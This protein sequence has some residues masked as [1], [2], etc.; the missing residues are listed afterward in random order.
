MTPRI[1]VVVLTYNRSDALLVVLRALAQ[2][3][4]TDDEVIVA[5]DGSQPE[6]VARIF[7]ECPTFSCAV[8]HVWH[9]DRGFTASRARNLGVAASTGSYLI[10]LDGDCVPHP[11]FLAQHRRLMTAGRFVNGSRVLLS[12]HLTQQ[13][14][15]GAVKLGQLTLWRWLVFRW[16]GHA[17]KW[18]W[19]LGLRCSG[20]QILT[21]W[22][23]RKRW[24]P[25]FVWKGIRSCNLGVWRT[26]FEAVNGFDETFAGWGHEDADLV[27]RLHHAGLTRTNGFWATEVF[28]LYHLEYPRANEGINRQ[29]IIDRMTTNVVAAA[30]G[31]LQLNEEKHIEIKNLYTP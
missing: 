3:C 6:H 20:N 29:R 16:Q 18:L 9:P 17:N 31:L 26:D 24:M 19:L 30:Q 28:H 4:T 25:R 13:V 21:S 1:S 7:S 11:D 14:L 15:S 23:A 10:F 5:D 8:R 27:L 2:Q 12:P 22:L